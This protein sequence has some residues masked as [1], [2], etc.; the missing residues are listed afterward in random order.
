[1]LP[2]YSALTT[3]PVAVCTTAC[4]AQNNNNNNNNTT[5]TPPPTELVPRIEMMIEC[6]D[7]FEQGPLMCNGKRVL[8]RSMHTLG[9]SAIY[10]DT[11]CG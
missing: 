7:M 1:M 4:W 9:T 2:F 3:N 6:G 11:D 10:M 5:R 8:H